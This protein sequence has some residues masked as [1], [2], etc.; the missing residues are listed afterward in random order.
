MR[1]RLLVL[2]VMAAAVALPAVAASPAGAASGACPRGTGVTVVV[3]GQVRCDPTPGSFARES[4]ADAGFSLA[5]VPD[6]PGAVCRIDG[7]P[8]DGRCFETD[9]YWA[10]FFSKPGSGT[11]QYASVGVN[12]QRVSAGSW[13]AFVWQDSASRKAPSQTPLGPV[14]A[15]PAP[16]EGSGT[17][18][19]GG[20]GSGSG[21]G[22]EASSSPG[23]SDPS[24]TPTPTPDP[25]ESVPPTDAPA[26]SAGDS[27]TDER[28]NTSA[29]VSDTGGGGPWGIVLAVLAIAGL[30]GAALVLQRRRSAGG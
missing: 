17:A 1:R 6:Q 26:G 30:G 3:D 22:G 8:G 14:P 10:L 9:A 13:V 7:F 18:P 15:A 24:A 11:W 23:P 21:G 2:L 16:G 20:S 12:G 28:R 25:T 19:G 5:D 29:E 4:F 27:A